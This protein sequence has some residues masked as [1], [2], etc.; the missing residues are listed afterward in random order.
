CFLQE[1]EGIRDS[2]VTGVQTCA[3]PILDK[4]LHMCVCVSECVCV[5]VCVDSEEIR[6][7]ERRV[8]KEWRS[9]GS[10][11][12]SKKRQIREGNTHS[13]T[14]HALYVRSTSTRCIAR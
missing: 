6:S 10:P 14:P 8:G 12:H 11:Y 13:T 7:E 2:S 9:R 3:L 5:C 4:V 1:E